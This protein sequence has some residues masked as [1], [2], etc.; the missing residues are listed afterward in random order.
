MSALHFE[1]VA[2]EGGR[3]DVAAL[4]VDALAGKSIRQ[5]EALPLKFANQ[6]VTVADIFR[7]RGSDTS[8]LVFSGDTHAL[9]GI[10]SGMT[11]GAVIIDGNAGA[12]V[13]DC[14][15]GGTLTVIGDCGAFAAS[16][17]RGGSVEIQGNAGPF[18]AAN[19]PGH[20]YGMRGGTLCVRGDVG[21]RACDRLRGGTVIVEGNTGVFP[22]SRLVAGT[23]IVGGRLGA[24]AGVEL[25]HGSILSFDRKARIINSFGDCG[26]HPFGWLSLFR[27]ALARTSPALAKRLPLS[28]HR[29]AGDLACAGRGEILVF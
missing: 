16:G 6:N 23:L 12:Y 29:Y 14:M 25:N 24:D 27:T 26:T 20:A 5:I 4:S 1:R 18:L 19:R 2:L 11:Q 28:A 22:G 9:D 13:A 8:Q 21:D 15:R 10:G 17:M 7:V 3:I